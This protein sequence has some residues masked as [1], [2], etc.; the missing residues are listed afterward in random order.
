[1]AALGHR[2]IVKLA[3]LAYCVGFLLWT[4]CVVAWASIDLSTALGCAFRSVPIHWTLFI[5]SFLGV[6]VIPWRESRSVINLK[7][8]ALPRWVAF[9]VGVC[10]TLAF[11][12][13]W[14]HSM[15]W[16]SRFGVTSNPGRWIGIEDGC[17]EYVD[18]A[19]VAPTYSVRP[20]LME[21]NE[22]DI[23]W[24]PS[25]ERGFSRAYTA[26]RVPLW[27]PLATLAAV[28]WWLGWRR[29]RFPAGHCQTCGYN[30]TGNVS[31]RCP[32]C[33][34]SLERGRG[35]KGEPLARRVRKHMVSWRLQLACLLCLLAVPI[36]VLLLLVGKHSTQQPPPEKPALPVGLPADVVFERFRE[37]FPD[38]NGYARARWEEFDH[39]AVEIQSRRLLA[40]LGSK[41]IEAR[42]GGSGWVGWTSVNEELSMS[43]GMGAWLL[44]HI[45]PRAE[46]WRYV[47]DEWN[48]DSGTRRHA[49]V[50]VVKSG[51]LLRSSVQRV[52]HREIEFFESATYGSPV[53]T[54]A[55]S[56]ATKQPTSR[57][58]TQSV[59]PP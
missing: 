36:F 29:R 20:T 25:V 16:G 46:T 57:N 1:M 51:R 6:L 32:E 13:L 9:W 17:V 28:T 52:K 45:A 53:T 4:A 55:A 30:L 44:R 11:L 21:Y 3:C 18:M 2:R 48:S 39:W 50:L 31:G 35:A 15:L 58:T 14:T 38:G 42:L 23:D 19:A 43:D 8:M 47:V 56:Q 5:C 7:R 22:L 12:I 54:Q 26:V 37:L 24:L 40:G 49:F 41:E 33:G 59:Q 27:I 34:M 10:A